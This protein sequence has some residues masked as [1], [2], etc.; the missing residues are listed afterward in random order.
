MA[1]AKGRMHRGLVAAGAALT[2]KSVGKTALQRFINEGYWPDDDGKAD[3]LP[4]D[5]GLV[6]NIVTTGRMG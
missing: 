2:S 3:T 5:Q 4:Y 1:T 6:K